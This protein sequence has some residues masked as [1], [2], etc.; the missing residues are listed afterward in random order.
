M[1][2]KRIAILLFSLVLM[3]GAGVV[4]ASAQRHW[5]GHR[6]VIVRPYFGFGYGWRDP[7]WNSWNYDP[8]FYDP[9][10]RAE[11][12]RYNL[13]NDVSSARKKIAKDREKYAKDGY[14]DPKEQEKLMKDQ[15]KYQEKVAKLNRYNRDRY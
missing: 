1:G 4:S 11:V 7:F 9:V 3:L 2:Y 6:A 13:Q 12:D 15:E 8:Y 5:H 14:I 10:Y